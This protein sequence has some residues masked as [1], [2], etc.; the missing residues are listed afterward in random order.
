MA[1]VNIGIAL[2]I[3]G[4]HLQPCAVAEDPGAL[5]NVVDCA[6]RRIYLAGLVLYLI[7]FGICLAE[8]NPA[9][10]LTVQ[11]S[12]RDPI[13]EQPICLP[14]STSAAEENV[15]DGASD[16]RGLR[17]GLRLVDYSLKGCSC[18]HSSCVCFIGSRM[19]VVIISPSIVTCSL[20]LPKV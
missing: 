15:L 18:C 14:S 17:P 11:I 4:S 7:E 13:T 1:L 8:E 16:E 5:A 2:R 10:V 6:N 12:V 19:I 3:E 9:R 20:G